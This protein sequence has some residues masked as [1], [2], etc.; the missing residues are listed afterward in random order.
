MR[1]LKFRK[2]LA[3]LADKEYYSLPE[4]HQRLHLAAAACGI[5]S[6]NIRGFWTFE[7]SFT[8]LDSLHQLKKEF[9]ITS[10]RIRKK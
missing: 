4:S 9:N 8:A 1:T 3:T 2:A 10:S 7:D 6:A 5:T